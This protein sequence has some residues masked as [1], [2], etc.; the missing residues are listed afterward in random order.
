MAYTPFLTW[1]LSDISPSNPTKNH[2]LPSIPEP[3]DGF[4]NGP[5]DNSFNESEDE[6][7]NLV[8]IELAYQAWIQGNSAL[9]I[10]DVAQRFGVVYLTL[11]SCIHSAI[12]R[13]LANQAMQRLSVAKEEAIK[14]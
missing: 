12:S 7:P 6:L 10:K 5:I 3:T 13:Q 14:D 1:K 4:I 9:K 8:R 11:Y 2:T